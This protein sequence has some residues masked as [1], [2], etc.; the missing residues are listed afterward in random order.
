MAYCYFPNYRPHFFSK[1]IND[2]NSVPS[3]IVI[4]TDN[5]YLFEHPLT[6]N[7][8]HYYSFKEINFIEVINNLLWEI[9]ALLVGGMC[10]L[11]I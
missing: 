10:T 7:K 6:V 9:T 3:G 5:N 4:A 11:F 8:V 2:K 1:V